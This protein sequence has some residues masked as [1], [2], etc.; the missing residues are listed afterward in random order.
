MLRI[1]SIVMLIVSKRCMVMQDDQ[2]PTLP[3]RTPACPSH[4]LGCH[5]VSLL[6]NAA[7]ASSLKGHCLLI[8]SNVLLQAQILSLMSDRVFKLPLADPVCTS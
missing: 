6:W 8:G 4:H 5:I 7:Y 1:R 2:V 3:G